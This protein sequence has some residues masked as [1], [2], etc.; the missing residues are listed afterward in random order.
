MIIDCIA[1]FSQPAFGDQRDSFSFAAQGGIC[2]QKDWID[3]KL[4]EA[5]QKSAMF[6][7]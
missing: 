6:F 7:S 4:A 3:L 5:I 1:D 2:K